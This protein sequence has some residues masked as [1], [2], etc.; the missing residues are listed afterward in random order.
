MITKINKE[1]LVKILLKK[2]IKV[3]IYFLLN[4]KIF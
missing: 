1:N 3:E 4:K 2:K